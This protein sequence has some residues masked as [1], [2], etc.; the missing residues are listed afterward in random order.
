MRTFDLIVIGSGAGL[1][2]AEEGV[3]RGLRVA[4]FES[5]PLGGTC[6]NRGCIPSKLLIRSA[7]VMDA[8]RRAHVW[9]IEV[10]VEGVD[11]NRVV[12][13][14]SSLVDADALE[15][16]RR[17]RQGTTL[18]RETVRFIGPKLLEAA[19]EQYSAERIVIAAGSR[20]SVPDIPGIEPVPYLT[21]DE[22]LR[23]AQQPRSLIIVGTGYVAAELAHFYGALGTEV[24]LLNRGERIL[25]GEDEDISQTF[26]DV[27]ERRFR[28]L[29]NTVARHVE[30]NGEGVSVEVRAEGED[31]R[32]QADALLLAT[33]RVANT[34]ALNLS[35]TGVRLNDKGFVRANEYLETDVPG[36]WT[37][38]DIAGRF[39]FRHS[40]NLE[41]QHVAYNIFHPEQQA[42]VDYH[43]MPHAVFGSPQVGG[44]GLTEA[45]ARQRGR[46]Y[47]TGR[48]NYIDTGYGL[49]LEDHDGFVKVIADA[50][51]R[52]ILGCHIIGS[53]AAVLV[54]EVVNAMRLHETVDVI[55][56]S[57]YIHP[58]LQEVVADAFRAI[59]WP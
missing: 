54:Q 37:L 7:D 39:M 46:P 2:V 8:V 36:I 28:V 45:E 34:E 44:V 17:V 16:E 5:G 22:A 40:A 56:A 1:I 35:A 3:R 58:A 21:S 42:P 14:V 15:V 24:T 53:D 57:I 43:A 48:A 13:R 20:P 25:A 27:Y 59:E 32:L 41:G 31:R 47:V 30:R 49:A 12:G 52:E 23:V 51:S 29:R 18:V 26:T 4:L 6:L 55:T 10:R 50:K 19:G 9:G 33:G 38:G 11:W